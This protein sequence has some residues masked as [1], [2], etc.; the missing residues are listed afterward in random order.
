M[1]PL[2][3]SAT[4]PQQ[5]GAGLSSRRDSTALLISTETGPSTNKGS[6]TWAASSGSG[7]TRSTDWQVSPTTN[8]E[9]SWRTFKGTRLTQSTTFLP[10]Q[11]KKT[12]TSWALVASSTQVTSSWES[13]SVVFA[14][15]D[16]GHQLVT[17]SEA[18]IILLYW[19]TLNVKWRDKVNCKSWQQEKSGKT[20]SAWWRSRRTMNVILKWNWR[21]L[22]PKVSVG[23][24]FA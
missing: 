14:G 8:C 19:Q 9:L 22:A 17:P 10:W 13:F 6:V 12:T 18:G 7:W 11:T 15:S 3:F 24:I 23:R 2:T 20:S 4:K 21:N 1:R 5:E 16:P